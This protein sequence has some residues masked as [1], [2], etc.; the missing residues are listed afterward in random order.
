VFLGPIAARNAA[1]LFVIRTVSSARAVLSHAHDHAA[2]L[3]QVNPDDLVPSY[4]SRSGSTG[5]NGPSGSWPGPGSGSPGYPTVPGPPQAL[6]AICDRLGPGTITVFFERWMSRIRPENV[7][8]IFGRAPKGRTGRPPKTPP[9][10]K[11]AI[12][13]YPFLGP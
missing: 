3:V 10:C 5:M 2:P 8:L 6:Q 1:G 12:D 9:V 11:T 4:D 13:R 7:E